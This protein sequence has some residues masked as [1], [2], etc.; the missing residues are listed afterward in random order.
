MIDLRKVLDEKLGVNL[1]GERY[2]DILALLVFIKDFMPVLSSEKLSVDLSWEPGQMT[3]ID[4]S[5][6]TSTLRVSFIND[7]NTPV[8]IVTVSVDNIPTF[9]SMKK[10]LDDV[11]SD[12]RLLM[13]YE[14]VREF[15]EGYLMNAVVIYEG[16]HFQ[17]T[18]S[19][20]LLAAIHP[21]KL[22]MVTLIL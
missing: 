15:L 20:L 8:T 17:S 16:E 21:E 3:Y 1:D 11:V 18:D 2:Y 5:S 14:P 22:Y 10:S 19:D 6:A 12:V 7:L 9:R 4:K 13:T